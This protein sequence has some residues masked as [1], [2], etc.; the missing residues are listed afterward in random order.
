MT[1]TNKPALVVMAAGLGSRYGGLKQVAIVDDC[2]HRLID[3]SLY[4]ARQAGFRRVVFVISPELEKDFRE[5][6]GDDTA[7]RMEVDY[8]YQTLDQLPKGFRI[9]DGRVKPW[10]TA[11]AVLSAKELVG[12]DFA[13]INADD[14]YGATA[15]KVLYDFLLD[16]AGNGRHAM[17]GY[18]LGNTLTE[19]GHVARGVCETDGDMLLEITERVHIEARP[20]G[21]AYKDNGGNFTFIP[22]DT[23]VSMNFWAFGYSMMEELERRFTGFLE[24]NLKKNPLKCEYF[25]PMVVNRVLQEGRAVINVLPTDEKWYGMTYAEDMP[26]LREALAKMGD[27]YS[28]LIAI[29]VKKNGSCSV[30][31]VN[32]CS[33]VRLRTPP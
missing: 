22:A 10:G 18:K 23:I 6:V 12:S 11:H 28:N 21:A 14:Y 26:V 30:P 24:E 4:D 29:S 7:K 8:A 25:L 33:D 3:Y 27:R 20:G 16:K 19:H 15:F 17:V 2:G 32:R 13:V 9:P 1:V 5:A 31:H